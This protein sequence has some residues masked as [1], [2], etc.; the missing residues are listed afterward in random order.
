MWTDKE[1]QGFETT[2]DALE[3]SALNALNKFPV[4]FPMPF[5]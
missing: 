4:Q 1:A 3:F 5:R 2:V